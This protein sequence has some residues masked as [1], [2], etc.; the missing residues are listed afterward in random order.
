MFIKLIR[1]KSIFYVYAF[2]RLWQRESFKRRAPSCSVMVF[3]HIIVFICHLQW[4]RYSV[5]SFLCEKYIWSISPCW[6]LLTSS[7]EKESD[8]SVCKPDTVLWCSMKM[9]S[10]SSSNS[11][12][13]IMLEVSELLI[14]SC[15]WIV[16]KKY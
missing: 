13:N 3:S 12:L 15:I 10:P 2:I 14:E 1:Q 7:I 8:Q 5:L 6:L 9:R 4:K 16:M 11:T